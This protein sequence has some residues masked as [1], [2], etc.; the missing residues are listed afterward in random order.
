MHGLL[1]FQRSCGWCRRMFHPQKKS[2]APRS[3]GLDGWNLDRDQKTI[4]ATSWTERELL[5]KL[6][7]HCWKFAL[8]G[9]ANTLV[10]VWLVSFTELINPAVY[11][12]WLKKLLKS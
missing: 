8:L 11:C 5:G 2:P 4:L 12:A 9:S 10:E 1:R 6:V 7:D 3:A